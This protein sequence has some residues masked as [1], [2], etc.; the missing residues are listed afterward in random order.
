M[1]ALILIVY[2]TDINAAEVGIVRGFTS[3]AACDAAGTLGQKMIR[4]SVRYD[5][6]CVPVRSPST[7]RLR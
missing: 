7:L 1:W 6:L 5:Y 2:T 3:E 4:R